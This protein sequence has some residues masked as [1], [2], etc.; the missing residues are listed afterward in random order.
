MS[1]RD[2]S[3]SRT[4]ITP[5]LRQENG[6]FPI[7]PSRNEES[8]N[9]SPT[10]IHHET[11]T[12]P[13]LQQRRTR[14]NNDNNTFRPLSV[15]TKSMLVP[16]NQNFDKAFD[17]LE[18]D[19]PDRLKI[20]RSLLFSEEGG[21][22]LDDGFTTDAEQES[23]TDKR[24]S[25]QRLGC[26]TSPE[27][28]DTASKRTRY[29]RQV[30][31]QEVA[32]PCRQACDTSMIRHKSTRDMNM[33]LITALKLTSPEKDSNARV[34]GDFVTLCELPVPDPSE[35][36]AFASRPFEVRTQAPLVFTSTG[37][38]EIRAYKTRG[39]KSFECESDNNERNVE[40]K[41]SLFGLGLRIPTP[42]AAKSRNAISPPENSSFPALV[43]SP[44]AASNLSCT[45][46][47]S[48]TAGDIC[49]ARGSVTIDRSA[50]VRN[51]S[52]FFKRRN[53]HERSDPGSPASQLSPRTSVDNPNLGRQDLVSLSTG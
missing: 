2:S 42:S 1:S 47:I 50:A 52:G 45:K 49:S 34:S 20:A 37:A 40:R 23:G 5:L 13:T 3:C 24:I 39:Y 6:T 36:P 17:I 9:Q 32:T 28:E 11:L 14:R 31:D 43:S 19:S 15:F 21:Q 26:A 4:T 33:D 27:D 46:E 7:T 25:Q 10:S 53:T 51:F 35:H 48:P 12:P 18:T 30:S 22:E 41:V 16:F 38:E 44:Y 29:P 8:A